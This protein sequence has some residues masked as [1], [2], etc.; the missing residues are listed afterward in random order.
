MPAIVA[1][2][3]LASPLHLMARVDAGS[4]QLF[5]QALKHSHPGVTGEDLAVRTFISATPALKVHVYFSGAHL[6]WHGSGGRAF[7]AQ[8]RDSCPRTRHH[9]FTFQLA[10]TPVN[11]HHSPGSL[12]AHAG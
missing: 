11:H 4:V 2:P 10:H 12:M 5:K 8:V 1:K 7:L 9:F 6:I 3:W